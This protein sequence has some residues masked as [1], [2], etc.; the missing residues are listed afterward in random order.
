MS[1]LGPM[2]FGKTEELL[3]L[4]R[5]ITTERDYSEKV[6]ER[7]DAEVHAFIDRAEKVAEKILSENKKALQKIAEVL[8]ER[9]TLEQEE[10]YGILKPFKIKPVT[11]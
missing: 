8:K 4:G 5:E 9:E 2:T 11:V 3:F 10:F 7:I 1:G 6:A